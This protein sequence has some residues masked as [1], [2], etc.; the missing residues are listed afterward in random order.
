MAKHAI[1]VKIIIILMRKEIVLVLIF[2]QKE[3][4]LA[5]VKNALMI[6]I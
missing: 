2:A 4:N 6:I 1:Y 3:E 5:N